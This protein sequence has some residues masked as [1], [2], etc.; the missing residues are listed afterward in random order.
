MLHELN[1]PSPRLFSFYSTQVTYAR[2]STL[3]GRK[4]DHPSVALITSA[5]FPTKISY[6]E[7]KVCVY[8]T[9]Y[10]TLLS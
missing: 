7:T 5:Y 9:S 6:N 3:L 1:H 2:L 10:P 8:I 4:A